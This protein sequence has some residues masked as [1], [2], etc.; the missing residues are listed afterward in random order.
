MVLARAAQQAPSEHAD[1]GPVRAPHP[2]RHVQGGHHVARAGLHAASLR[3]HVPEGRELEVPG[4]RRPLAQPRDGVRRPP[5]EQGPAA[6]P[7]ARLD[8]EHRRDRQRRRVEGVRPGR[9]GTGAGQLGAGRLLLRRRQRARRRGPRRQRAGRPQ[10][11]G[12]RGGH[13]RDRVDDRRRGRRRRGGHAGGCHDRGGR[14]HERRG[15]RPRRPEPRQRRQRPHQR[16]GQARLQDGG[17]RAGAGRGGHAVEGPGL[18]DPHALPRR[19]GNG[20]RLGQ[21][22]VR[23]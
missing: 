16:G 20:R 17:A 14:D 21:H 13:R 11:P 22:C 4:P 8:E 7:A 23:R 15:L 1:R 9:P 12:R 19:P 18:R 3:E 2:R 5:A 6:P 10:A